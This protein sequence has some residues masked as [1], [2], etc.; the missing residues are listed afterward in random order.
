[1][2]YRLTYCVNYDIIKSIIVEETFKKEVII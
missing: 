1:M 2:F